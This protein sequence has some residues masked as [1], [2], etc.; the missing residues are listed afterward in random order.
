MS[1]LGVD[2]GRCAQGIAHGVR[3]RCKLLRCFGEDFQCRRVAGTSRL[4]PSAG[5]ALHAATLAG[6]PLG[7]DATNHLSRTN[8]NREHNCPL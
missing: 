7:A 5:A 1:F 8:A 2:V 6:S 4:P 3:K